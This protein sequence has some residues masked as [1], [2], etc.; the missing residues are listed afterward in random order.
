VNSVEATS[1][2]GVDDD[3]DATVVVMTSA[4]VVRRLR[5]SVIQP[6][7]SKPRDPP[8]MAL[9]AC[10][11]QTADGLIDREDLPC[12]RGPLARTGETPHRRRDLGPAAVCGRVCY[13]Q[14]GGIR[15]SIFAPASAA[16]G[17]IT[18]TPP[19]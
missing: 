14:R 6:T 18:R 19:A 1:G 5:T 15:S 3:T 7:P 2:I 13:L 9:P 12:W 8:T 4:T 10:A 17:S 16:S 11:R